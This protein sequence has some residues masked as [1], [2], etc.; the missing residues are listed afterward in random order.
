MK[1]IS[2]QKRLVAIDAGIESYELLVA[3]VVDGASVIILQSDRDGV[4][5]ITDALQNYRDITSLH[6][7]SHGSPGCLYLGSTQ[8]S[9]DTLDRYAFQ[10]LQW[11]SPSLLLYGCN[12]AAGDAGA[13]FMARLH[14]L[15][16]ANIAASTTLTGNAEKGG[17]W[18]LEATVGTPETSLGFREQVI[19]EYASILAPGDLDPNFGSGGKVTTDF[20][21]DDEGFRLVLQPDGKIL[22][23]GR[24]FISGNDDFAVARYNSN[25][26]L[27]TSFG[28]GGKV[29][30][31]IGS[32]D[33]SGQ[34]IA[35][36][37]DGKIL[38]GG[39]GFNFGDKD[40]ALARYNSNGV[41]DTSFGT[42]G[43][44]TTYF[45]LG[46]DE[47]TG[48]VVQPDGK[49]LTSGSA[50]INGDDFAL[51]R[52]NSDGTLDTSFGT[53]GT[54]TKDFGF[55]EDDIY[56]VL[57]QSD[58]KILVAG[59]ARINGD[60]DF[61]LARYNSNGTLD[62]SFGTGGTV[63][64][65]FFGFNDSGLSVVLQADGKILVA[66]DAK[67][68]TSSDF[69]VA[70]YNSNGTLDTSF[71][72]GGKVTTDFFGFD[73]NAATVLLQSNGKILAAGT[74]QTAVD[75]DFGLVRYNSDGSLDTSF[76]NNGKVVT[77]V[78]SGDVVADAALQAD[79]RLLVVGRSLTG[80]TDDFALARYVLNQAPTDLSLS[81]T[82]IAENLPANTAVGTLTAADSDANDTQI[83]TLVAGTGDTDNAA[84][85]IEGN[86]L[87]AKQ[88]FDF[89]TK[90]SYSIRVQTKDSF[91]A[92]FEKQF[93]LAI[94]DVNEGTSAKPNIVG[95]AGNN[96]IN[97][98]AQNN[99]IDGKEG[100]DRLNGFGGD[101]FI[102]G[103]LGN[104]TLIG[105]YGNDTLQG[106]DGNDVIL[107]T[108]GSDLL[109]GG[110]GSDQFGFNTGVRFDKSSIGVATITDFI[111]GVDKLVLSRSTFT[112]PK[113][114]KFASVETRREAKDS[115]AALTYVRATGAL[116]YNQNGVEKGFGFGGKFA[117][118]TDGLKLTKA[119]I[120]IV[121]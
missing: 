56:D 10:L 26:T 93:T 84:F 68:S 107:G 79:G 29:T 85:T 109:T 78:G 90:N 54:V 65:D 99:T 45:G 24:T 49:I 97:G 30:T 36:Q 106:G 2:T 112:N 96:T 18:Q 118:L 73:D 98:D 82:S 92:T 113:K 9:L 52:Y 32:G 12:V 87:K 5:Q 116:F 38:V 28:T 33:D 121:G 108:L 39:T 104:D 71:G 61:A 59:S 11:F 103:G 58:G 102:I 117:D 23:T 83:Y 86:V 62:T 46:T 69:A 115:K 66:G 63:T 120:S 67:T 51:A 95:D 35:L 91:G 57:L 114:L 44:T 105:G 43:K 100:D 88:S 101:D 89:E 31:D 48:I 42:G 8:L 110:N 55:G 76:G 119:D 53:G 72:I 22:A 74:I 80:S 37:P 75:S 94:G 50:G 17:N 15:T 4:E 34:A 27:D 21:D 47:I 14:Q 25:G 70:R 81:S 60:D 3:G 7:V 1:S 20:G 111:H 16:G 19:K 6:I 77:N 40:F 41:L 13:E 64:T